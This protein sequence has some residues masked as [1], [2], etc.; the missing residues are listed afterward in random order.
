MQTHNKK[1]TLVFLFF[2]QCTFSWAQ[3]VQP[4]TFRVKEADKKLIPFER[5]YIQ[6][7]ENKDGTIAFN[8][9]LTRKMDR[10]PIN[11]KEAWLTVQTYQ[12]DKFID[13]DSSF[14]EAASLLPLYYR[15]SI[16]S[17]GHREIVDFTTHE[18]TNQVIYKDSS[19][20]ALK[21][22]KGSYNGVIADDIISCMPLA[23]NKTFIIKS[24]NPGLRYIEFQVKLTVEAQEEIEIPGLGKVLC[25]RLRMGDARSTSYQWYTVKEQVQVKKRFTFANGNSWYR[26]LI[27]G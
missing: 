21:P 2:S 9:L 23:L 12:M 14:C 15:T 11:G 27:A 25:W 16:P 20:T 6:Y 3:P 8:A 22:N 19:K 17:E 7:T 26:V 24:V 1:I 10:V 13:R 5:K 18:I 4:D